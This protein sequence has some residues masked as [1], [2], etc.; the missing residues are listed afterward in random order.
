MTKEK[1]QILEQ[2]SQEQLEAQHTEESTSPWNSPVFV[3]NKKNWQMEINK[4]IQ[5][6]GSLQP[7]IPLPPLLPKKW[8]IIVID[9]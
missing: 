1:L 9:L 8:P 4:I 6:M 7:G 5:P 2:L 3:I